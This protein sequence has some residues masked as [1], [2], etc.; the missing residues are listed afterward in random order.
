MT[1]GEKQPETYTLRPLGIIKSEI[2]QPAL[3]ANKNGIELNTHIEKVRE[4]LPVDQKP[5]LGDRNL[6]GI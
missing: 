5:G 4:Q 3:G 6:P 1:T 2:Q